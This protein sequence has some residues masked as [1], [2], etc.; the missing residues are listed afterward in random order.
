M[1][2]GVPESRRRRAEADAR[3]DA[4]RPTKDGR[5]RSPLADFLRA[6]T[7]SN[8]R[9]LVRA[10]SNGELSVHDIQAAIASQII[11]TRKLLPGQ[12]RTSPKA[13]EEAMR[14]ADAQRP[15]LVTLKQLISELREVVTEAG[16]GGGPVFVVELHWPE[17][18]AA[19]DHGED[20]RLRLPKDPA[21]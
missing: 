1:K 5:R 7:T 18:Y 12:G 4:K 10:A 9:E 14:H 8:E 11:A 19:V 20:V 2:A 15:V 21:S 16:G 13:R 17:A 3:S 6:P